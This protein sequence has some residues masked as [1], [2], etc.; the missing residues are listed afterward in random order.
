[1]ANGTDTNADRYLGLLKDALLGSI[2]PRLDGFVWPGSY[3][4]RWLL[5]KILPEDVVFFRRMSDE[6]RGQTWPSYAY[7]MVGPNRLDNIR[8]CLEDV[9]KH[10]IPGDFIETG[11]WRGGSCIYARAVLKANS[12]SD[13]TVWVADS[14]EGLPRPDAQKYPA[15]A[16]DKHYLIPELAVSMDEVKANFRMFDLLDDRV[17][18]LK[19]WFKD[20]LPKA[21]FQKLAVARL[22]GDL[23]ESTMDAL[24]NLY[25]KVSVGGYLIVDDYGAVPACKKAIH[26]YRDANGIKDPIREIDTSGVFW[27]KS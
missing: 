10:N 7:S 25:S 22:D 15:D 6:T 18:F 12:V 2:Y 14:F 27:Q 19:G 4:L 11:V 21:P 26:D 5:R 16:G 9:I 23:Y 20:T 13:R 17:Q 8:F 1:M 24:S 3:P